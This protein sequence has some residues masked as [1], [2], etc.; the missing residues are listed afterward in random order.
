MTDETLLT[1]PCEFPIK[2]M[3]KSS[4]TFEEHVVSI[5]ARHVEESDID[6]VSSK[7]SRDENYLSITVKIHAQNRAQLDAIY[8]DLTDSDRV[9]MVL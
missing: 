6:Q 2:V 5:I 1:F 7:S 4:D 3:G 9:I 8:T